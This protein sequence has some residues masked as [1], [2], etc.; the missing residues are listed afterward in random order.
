MEMRQIEVLKQTL[1]GRNVGQASAGL[2]GIALCLVGGGSRQQTMP[3]W[4]VW[5]VARWKKYTYNIIHVIYVYTHIHIIYPRNK[6]RMDLVVNLWG[7]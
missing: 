2:F 7:S 1:G 4:I 6:N 5:E 3:L